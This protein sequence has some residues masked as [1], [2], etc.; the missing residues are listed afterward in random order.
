M[1]LTR[2]GF[3]RFQAFLMGGLFSG[4]YRPDLWAGLESGKDKAQ[5]R[6]CLKAFTPRR[7]PEAS[8][9]KTDQGLLLTRPTLTGKQSLALNEVGGLI[10]ERCDGTTNLQEIVDS[11]LQQY[12]VDEETCVTDTIHHLQ[13]LKHYRMI[14][15]EPSQAS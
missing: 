2:R 3:V 14:H 11:I 12:Q 7:N 13:R 1:K 15:I 4:K 5:L 10:W 8:A 9:S 6:Q